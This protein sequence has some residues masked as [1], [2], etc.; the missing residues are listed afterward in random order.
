[1]DE[2]PGIE[3]TLRRGLALHG[4][5]LLGVLPYRPILSN[6]TLGMI[7]EG[8][9]GTL[10]E[11]GP[12][13]DRVIGNVAIAAMEPQHVMEHVR[14]DTLVICPGDREDVILT[15]TTARLVGQPRPVTV[16]EL[17][18]G[19]VPHASAT[20]GI[21]LVLTGGYAP[22]DAVLA[23]IRQAGM[24]AAIVDEDTYTVASR[25]HDLLVKTHAG[26][27]GKI[28]MIKALVWDHLEIDRVLDAA[29]EARFA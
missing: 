21:G 6:P 25:I 22:R 24:F 8:V 13:L 20:P 14:A 1:M 26:D 4:I 18:G 11:P 27:A 12:D 2:Q 5:P 16:A 23:A 7:L 17:I 19:S 3:E 15:L 10:I 9:R 28:E 29:T